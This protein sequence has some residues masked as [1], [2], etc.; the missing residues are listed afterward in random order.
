MAREDQSN[1]IVT[2][3]DCAN[4]MYPN[5]GKFDVK[6]GDSVKI[7]FKGENGTESMWVIVKKVNGDVFEGILNNDPVLI[8]GIS[9]GDKVIFSKDEVC[10]RI[11]GQIW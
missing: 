10:G 4:N 7:V 9:C 5:K 3:R 2:C 8:N 6:V 11:R 1:I